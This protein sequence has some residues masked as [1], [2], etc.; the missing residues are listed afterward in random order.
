MK[1][2]WYYSDLR[3]TSL[4]I[5]FSTITGNHLTALLFLPLQATPP[6]MNTPRRQWDR[7]EFRTSVSK[8]RNRRHL[9]SRAALPCPSKRPLIQQRL[10]LQLYLR[11][12]HPPPSAPTWKSWRPNRREELHNSSARS[13]QLRNVSSPGFH[14]MTKPYKFL[15]RDSCL[16]SQLWKKREWLLTLQRAILWSAS[17]CPS[18]RNSVIFLYRR[19]KCTGSFFFCSPTTPL[20]FHLCLSLYSLP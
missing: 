2:C 13:S 3:I 1:T 14:P 20:I 5:F 18:M 8:L 16:A 15:R 19:R 17:S 7:R 6:L 10:W 12:C 9:P 4:H 11:Q